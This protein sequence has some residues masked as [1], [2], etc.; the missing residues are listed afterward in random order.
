MG[1]LCHKCGMPLGDTTLYIGGRIFQECGPYAASPTPS[2]PEDAAR[3]VGI[4]TAGADDPMWANH[5]EVPK[6]VCAAA[7]ALI[8]SLSSQLADMRAERDH[9]QKLHDDRTRFLGDAEA[10]RD[11]LAAENERLR[12]A[13]TPSADT[14]AAYW[15]EFYMGV[16]L[17]ARGQEDCRRIQIP[18][19][20]IKE[21]MA[22]IT[23]RAALDT[24]KGAE[25]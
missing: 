2:L 17:H 9:W 11:R 8:Q 12:E 3:V 16:T 7:A 24:A 6:K 18:W 20:S 21:I 13:L 19:T 5:A 4:L 15:G 25:K 22:A 1:D 10:E 14:K 23:A